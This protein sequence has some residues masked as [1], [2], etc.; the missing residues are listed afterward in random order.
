MWSSC[1]AE[2]VPGRY[3]HNFCG[4]LPGQPLQGSLLFRR[5]RPTAQR[6]YN[7]KSLDDIGRCRQ[8]T[9]D[10]CVSSCDHT[11]FSNGINGVQAHIVNGMVQ[12][13]D[14]PRVEI[15]RGRIPL[16]D[17]SAT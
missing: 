5:G 13:L 14:E 10:K 11:A 8:R 4:V 2:G 3:P 1:L 9:L 12:C 16:T 7:F 17:V 15:L 6:R